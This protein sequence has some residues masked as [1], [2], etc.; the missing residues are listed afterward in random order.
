MTIGPDPMTMTVLMSSR[1]GTAVGYSFAPG[2]F[3]MR[4]SAPRASIW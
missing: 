3:L 4:T 2:F 1:F